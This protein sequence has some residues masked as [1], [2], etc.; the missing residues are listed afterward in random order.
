MEK[1]TAKPMA[2][3]MPFCV[4]GRGEYG[5]INGLTAHGDG[6]QIGAPNAK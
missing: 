2:I 4:D 3:M 1:S 6:I 5:E